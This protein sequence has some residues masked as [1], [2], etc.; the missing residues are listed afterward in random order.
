MIQLVLEVFKKKL[1]PELHHK[2]KLPIVYFYSPNVPD[3]CYLN[4]FHAL[5][6]LQVLGE[7]SK[8]HRMQLGKVWVGRAIA[9]SI[10]KKYPT[11]IR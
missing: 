9:Y 7:L 10:M 1:P 6:A 5:H 11:A 3:S 2:Q 4:D 8:L